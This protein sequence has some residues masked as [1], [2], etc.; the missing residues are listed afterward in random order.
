MNRRATL[1]QLEVSVESFLFMDE[2]TLLAAESALTQRALAAGEVAW[3]EGDPVRDVVRVVE[4][5]LEVHK[6]GAVVGTL[7]PNS[8]YGELAV[9]VHRSPAVT[10]VVAAAPSVLEVANIDQVL[11]NL[12]APQ[13]VRVWR[14]LAEAFAAR[15]VPTYADP[16]H[17]AKHL[18]SER[19]DQVI[20]VHPIEPSDRG[21]VQDQLTAAF[22]SHQ[23]VVWGEPIDAAALPGFVAWADDERVGLLT[24]RVEGGAWQVVGLVASRSGRGVGRRLL[25]AAKEAAEAAG[26]ATLWLVTTNDNT[27][28]LRFY[29]RFGFHLSAFSRDSLTRARQ[30]LQP[31]LPTQGAHGIALRDELRLE[32]P[33]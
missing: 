4:G 14:W 12:T 29:Q 6:G 17:V 10:T 26:A 24:Y 15:L 20:Q 7:G 23:V 9:L 1:A 11:Q 28:A 5:S 13:Q 3:R 21:F 31:A 19:A 32:L 2:E 25:T 18:G 27:D 22:A 33:L 8:A 30:T 16:Q